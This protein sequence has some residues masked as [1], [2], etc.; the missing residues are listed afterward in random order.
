MRALAITTLMV[1]AC[2]GG[3]TLPRAPDHVRIVG[4]QPALQTPS[5]STTV[6]LGRHETFEA[7]GN[8]W[9]SRPA[10]AYAPGP[11]M[12]VGRI[13]SD[14]P[15]DSEHAEQVVGT[16]LL[17]ME[18]CF[19]DRL[20]S[21]T[22]LKV[23]TA[24]MVRVGTQ[25][26]VT[27][28]LGAQGLIDPQ[29]NACV[30]DLL[31][32]LTFPKPKAGS[33]LL[34]IPL[35]FDS[36]GRPIQK[37][38]DPT[39]AQRLG[40]APSEPWTPFA[41]QFIRVDGADSIA[42]AT[43]AEVQRRIDALDACFVKRGPATTGSV[44]AI[45]E[46]DA[47]GTLLEASAGGLGDREVEVCIEQALSTI[48]VIAPAAVG[49]EIACDLARGDAQ[50][51]H[52]S[53]DGG[54][55]VVTVSASGVAHGTTSLR[56]TGLDPV[57]L[58]TTTPALVVLDPKAPG[59]LVLF[60]LSYVSSA[61]A[62]VFAVRAG[63][64]TPR[65]LAM[66]LTSASTTS[67]LGDP[68]ALFPIVRVSAKTVTACVGRIAE[69]TPL[70]SPGLVSGLLRKVADQCS[71]KHCA[72]TLVLTLDADATTHDLLDVAGSLRRAGFQ[73]VL[74]TSELGCRAPS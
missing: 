42:Q 45:L 23:A 65:Y 48:K 20:T 71:T 38:P 34:R 41:N 14:D 9:D 15:F 3:S 19:R 36:L 7:I 25:G 18:A 46:L 64:P 32:S 44:R 21:G 53:P 6:P 12:A 56:P 54:Y 74:L 62:A 1:A 35:I 37:E 13:T 61:P 22:M 58:D 73:R 52:V 49:T 57:P 66:G 2:G 24:W 33:A 5:L 70:A 72:G 55:D 8:G 59:A 16:V 63:E 17:Q 4:C 27:R 29:T 39:P 43:R 31:K 26:A 51:W 69:T 50:P 60:A 68:E 11:A 30:G 10:E 28:V 67:R 47:T 40:K